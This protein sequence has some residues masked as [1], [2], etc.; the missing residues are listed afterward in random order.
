MWKPMPALV[1]ITKL[2][3]ISGGRIA[4]QEARQAFERGRSRLQMWQANVQWSLMLRKLT[5]PS[6]HPFA[7]EVGCE[8][9]RLRWISVIASVADLAVVRGYRVGWRL[10][11]TAASRRTRGVG[12]SGAALDLEVHSK[13]LER[14][15]GRRRKE[16]ARVRAKRARQR[17]DVGDLSRTEILA[18]EERER[19]LE[20]LMRGRSYA[21]IVFALIFT[22]FFYARFVSRLCAMRLSQHSS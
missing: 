9:V 4:A 19:E 10:N 17:R 13:R 2:Q 15:V 22:A 20:R 6:P 3:H 1:E 16:R 14:R 11:T 8:W 7:S 5:M 21:R 12:S 18:V